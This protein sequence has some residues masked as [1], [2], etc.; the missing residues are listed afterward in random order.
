[1]NRVECTAKGRVQGVGYRLFV[2]GQ[3]NACKV[4]GWVRNESDE[5]V[6]IVAEGE[7]HALEEFVKR[8]KKSKFLQRIESLS[9]D[10]CEAQSEFDSFNVKY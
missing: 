3:A 9:V 6:R 2:L 1:M 10:W 7:K 4:K 8:I 5:T